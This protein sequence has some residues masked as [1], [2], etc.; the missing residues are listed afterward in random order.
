MAAGGLLVATVGAGLRL[1]APVPQGG[2]TEAR[3]RG[4]GEG[5]TWWWSGRRGALRHRVSCVFARKT[6]QKCDLPR[7]RW[8]TPAFALATLSPVAGLLLE[9]G[10]AR[11]V[12]TRPRAWTEKE[13]VR[14]LPARGEPGR[15]VQP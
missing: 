11:P 1:P 3:Q 2:I 14:P 6:T 12:A 13:V 10:G 5:L 7:P 4:R 9:I 15:E 8:L